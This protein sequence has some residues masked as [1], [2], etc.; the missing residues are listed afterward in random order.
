MGGSGLLIPDQMIPYVKQVLNGTLDPLNDRVRVRRTKLHNRLAWPYSNTP[1][2]SYRFFDSDPSSSY[3][4]NLKSTGL[5]GRNVAV[6]WSLGFKVETG[7]KIDG[8]AATTGQ[9]ISSSDRTALLEAIRTVYENGIVN[10]YLGD[11]RFIND[12]HGLYNFPIGNAVDVSPFGSLTAP[13]AAGV[14][15]NGAPLAANRWEFATPIVVPPATLLRV[16]LDFQTGLS[17]PSAATADSVF[18]M[19]FD[20]TI[21]TDTTG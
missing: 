10:A 13:A 20:A 17:P 19:E 1:G 12:V 7:Y 6:L 15:N 14:I 21:I 3:V 5:P 2:T 8:A 18:K 9:Q 16:N 11:W 4:G